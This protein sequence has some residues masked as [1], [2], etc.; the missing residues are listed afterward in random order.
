METQEDMWP[1][2]QYISTM[3]S[4][5]QAQRGKKKKEFRLKQENR[6]ISGKRFQI[7]REYTNYRIIDTLEIHKDNIKAKDKI[8]IK[9][10]CHPIRK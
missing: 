1:R 10:N 4:V 6:K 5:L 7:K 2:K 8:M 3:S 9:V